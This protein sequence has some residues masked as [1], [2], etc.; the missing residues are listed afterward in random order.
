MNNGRKEGNDSNRSG[1]GRGGGQ[2][3][4]TERGTIFIFSIFILF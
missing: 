2:E 4:T 3:E 1:E